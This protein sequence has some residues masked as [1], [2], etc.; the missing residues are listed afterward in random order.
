[1]FTSWSSECLTQAAA[2]KSGPALIF[3][4]GKSG[5]IAEPA[6]NSQRVVSAFAGR[7]PV[8]TASAFAAP[9][10]V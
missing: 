7:L 3:G 5:G 8:V 1:M 9:V 10:E 6:W 4:S 2:A